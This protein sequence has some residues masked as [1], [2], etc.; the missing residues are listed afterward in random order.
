MAL[1]EQGSER[2]DVVL[3]L[4]TNI[5]ATGDVLAATQ[6]IEKVFV[7]GN[8]VVLHDIRVLDEDDQGQAIDLLFLRSNTSIGA[9][10][11]A[12]TPTDAVGRE[13]LKKVSI[14]AGNYVDEGAW[15]S[16]YKSLVDGIGCVLQPTTGKSLFLAAVCRSGTPTY[17]AAG[18]RVQFGVM[19][20]G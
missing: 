10:N 12:Y 4:D 5:Y 17:T 13:I 1:V 7:R 3:T 11:A 16:A 6:E 19:Q 9:E 20:T 2:F 8:Q 18:I 15:Q 14:A